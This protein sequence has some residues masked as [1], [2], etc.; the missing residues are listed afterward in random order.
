[1]QSDDGSPMSIDDITAA[2]KQ[3]IENLED[4]NAAM[5]KDL[6]TLEDKLGHRL[7]NQLK[8]MES[9]ISEKEQGGASTKDIETPQSI[10]KKIDTEQLEGKDSD[11]ATGHGTEEIQLTE[12]EKKMDRDRESTEEC[13]TL[14]A[15][16][17]MEQHDQTLEE[18]IADYEIQ[19]KEMLTNQ[20][21]LKTELDTL[22]LSIGPKLFKELCELS[23]DEE[24]GSEKGKD[25]EMSS[26]KGK[27]GKLGFE[28]GKDDEM[29]FGKLKEDT[30]ETKKVTED[31]S[32]KGQSKSDFE[33]INKM[34]EEEKPLASILEDYQNKCD[35]L[36]KEN[37][38]MRKALDSLSGDG[39][40]TGEMISKYENKIQMLENTN[41]EAEK[42]FQEKHSELQNEIDD[43]RDTLEKLAQT[44]RHDFLDDLIKQQDRDNGI[45][46]LQK[47]EKENKTLAEVV[48]EY[49]DN[50]KRLEREKAVLEQITGQSE[51]GAS[52]L[53]TINDYEDS[54]QSLKDVNKMLNQRIDALTAKIGP[55]LTEEIIELCEKNYKKSEKMKDEKT[56][57]TKE[58][59]PAV[60]KMKDDNATLEEVLRCYEDQMRKLDS[61]DRGKDKQTSRKYSIEQDE[62]AQNSD[63]VLKKLREKIGETFTNDINELDNKSIEELEDANKR[64]FV[65]LVMKKRNDNLADVIRLYEDY[66]VQ[67]GLLDTIKG[68][69]LASELEA[70]TREDN[71]SV[72]VYHYEPLVSEM[73]GA[74]PSFGDDYNRNDNKE[75]LEELQKQLEEEKEL[76]EK[77]QKDVEDLL[78]DILKLKLK[79]ATDDGDREEIERQ[80][81]EEYESKQ[82]NQ[83]LKEELAKEKD[84]NKELEKDSDELKSEIKNMEKEIKQLEKA[85]AEIKR[86]LKDGNEDLKRKLSELDK[87][88][89]ELEKEIE[90]LKSQLKE[91]EDT[92]QT[93]KSNLL[94]QTEKEKKDTIKDLLGAKA[95]VELKLQEQLSMYHDLEE[96][97]KAMEEESGVEEDDRMALLK[98]RN[99]ALKEQL[100]YAEES[101]KE[102]LE[103]FKEQIKCLEIEN[104]KTEEEK[105]HEIE[106]LNNK[107]E[108]ERNAHERLKEDYDEILKKEKERMLEDFENDLEREKRRTKKDFEEQ[109]EDFERI[110]KRHEQELDDMNE[111]SKKEKVELNNLFEEE[112]R[113]LQK[114]FDEKL[115]Q[116]EEEHQRILDKLREELEEQMITQKAELNILFRQEKTE[117]QAHIEKNIYGDEIQKNLDLESDFQGTLNKVLKEHAKEIEDIDREMKQAEENFKMQK[118]Q[119][120]EEFQIEREKDKKERDKLRQE[121]E[122]TIENMLKE[123]IKLKHQRKEMRHQHR[124]ENQNMEEVFDNERMEIQSSIERSKNELVSKLKEEHEKEIGNEREKYEAMV[125]ELQEALEKAESKRKELEEKLRSEEFKVE[126]SKLNNEAE[127]K[128]SEVTKEIKVIKRSIEIEYEQK[129]SIEKQRFEETLQGLRREVGN[130]SEKRKIIQERVY[131][132]ESYSAERHVMEKSIANYK[133]EVLAKLEGE[134]AQKLDRERKP[135]EDEIK[136]LQIETED[137]KRQRWEMK[138]QFRREKAVIEEAHEKE[139]ETL[140]QNFNKEREDMRKRLEATLQK[141]E[142][143]S[144]GHEIRFSHAQSPRHGE[145]ISPRIDNT[146]RMLQQENLSLVTQNDRLEADVGKLTEKLESLEVN[147]RGMLETEKTKVEVH[148]IQ[149][150]IAKTVTFK[151]PDRPDYRQPSTSDQDVEDFHSLQEKDQQIHQLL[152]TKRYYESVLGELCD[153]AGLFELDRNQVV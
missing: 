23:T 59:L 49:E 66:L 76:K 62:V 43:L 147:F 124:M 5:R 97:M 99:E 21:Q 144:K 68:D 26:E 153:E 11:T 74:M 38:S 102:A 78:D 123:I 127:D 40:D 61:E 133:I 53:D 106:L 103:K 91:K 47:M 60:K 113:Q 122:M 36:E 64:P 101:M 44:L 110:K 33:A 94:E 117:L 100:D 79:N 55:K 107:L 118:Y 131:N 83:R 41:K 121:M 31:S 52:M 9:G 140:E 138:V 30:K 19:L 29:G 71:V 63:E 39:S 129:L 2:Y 149:E 75:Q 20:E 72:D 90:N 35:L 80:I 22:E 28:K 141:Q 126:E 93:E 105:K 51:D 86:N 119:L 13:S 57:E 146:V 14:E 34:T 143:T 148:K 120:L 4:D 32:K 25:D 65:L 145:V 3:Q 37:A 16:I 7:A 54:I 8:G 135:L 58:T 73:T 69:S 96:K 77:Y 98:S 132:Q 104:A 134:M 12:S 150:E 15:P 18:V 130:L 84:K 67:Y 125:M 89:E 27:D 81:K 70:A 24:L 1:M 139:K 46:A 152:E 137:L 128:P 151:E 109:M 56:E 88:N 6:G 42:D 82:E 116:Q 115:R 111:K 108:L 10:K 112:K 85:L 142:K 87:K 45:E 48:E 50:M 136:E 92:F 17:I 95:E 114:T